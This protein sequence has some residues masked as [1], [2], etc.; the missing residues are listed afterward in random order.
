[1]F[2]QCLLHL[3]RILQHRFDNFQPHTTAPSAS[4]LSTPPLP[5]SHTTT[6]DKSGRLATSTGI[7]AVRG[8]SPE[9]GSAPSS[10]FFPFPRDAPSPVLACVSLSPP[11]RVC[12]CVCPQVSPSPQPIGNCPR[13]SLC[14]Q[15]R[16]MGR[17]GTNETTTLEGKEKRIGGGRGERW[18]VCVETHPGFSVC[19]CVSVVCV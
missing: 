1:M 3:P 15:P 2:G 7:A 16:P 12:V 6:T 14:C 4:T 17:A 5:T 13:S 19:V 11:C 8:M 18:C 9:N 10:S